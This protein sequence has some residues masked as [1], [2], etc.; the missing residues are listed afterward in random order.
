VFASDLLCGPCVARDHATVPAATR[1]VRQW[2][3]TCAVCTSP[4]GVGLPT[5]C[6]RRAFPASA[7]APCH[8]SPS[9]YLSSELEAQQDQVRH[10]AVCVGFVEFGVTTIQ[11]AMV[12][13]LTVLP[14]H[15][16][17]LRVRVLRPAGSKV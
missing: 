4:L 10:Q 7:L 1:L 14:V 9:L 17:F 5:V 11:P 3:P 2:V 6:I 8:G 16:R 13:L 12:S 15:S